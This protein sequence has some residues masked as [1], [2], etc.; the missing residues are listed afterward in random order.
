MDANHSQSLP[1]NEENDDRIDI[2]RLHIETHLKFII[3]LENQNVKNPSYMQFL[4]EHKKMSGIYWALSSL[5]LI[6]SLDKL[7]DTQRILD[8]V[9]SCKKENGGYGGNFN[10][11]AHILYTLSAVQILALLDRMDLVDYDS[12]FAYIASLQN[13]DGS[14]CGD[15]YGSEIDTRFSYAAL[16]CL[17][18]LNR[19]EVPVESLD[20]IRAPEPSESPACVNVSK[21]VD[22]VLSCRNFDG[23]FGCIPLAESHAG[24]VFCCVGA[25]ALTKS[26]HR[27]DQDTL[28][29]WLSQRQVEQGGLNGRPDKKEDV[30][31]SWWVLSSLSMLNKIHWI[32]KHKLAKFIISSQDPEH[33]G[34]A[35]RPHDK[36]D[37]FHTFFGLA[38]LS[39]LG[40]RELSPISP[41]YAL[42]VEVVERVEAMDKKGGE[43]IS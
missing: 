5:Y 2:S 4:L 35:D 27:I 25:L 23:G 36:P 16:L 11:D 22:F 41:M 20:A 15:H 40:C 37:I 10:Q 13:P 39:L 18:I 12:V 14:F 30:C 9:S 34:I 19:L 43:Q 38:G 17:K 1:S 42:P 28:G 24:Q 31:Y 6:H 21:A 8:F 29:W 7:P 26:L 32:D 3:E 33:G